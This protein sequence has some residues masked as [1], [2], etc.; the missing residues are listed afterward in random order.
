[1]DKFEQAKSG[2]TLKAA[3]EICEAY[4]AAMLVLHREGPQFAEEALR[5][6]RAR[7]LQAGDNEAAALFYNAI[8]IATALAIVALVDHG[9][10]GLTLNEN[11]QAA[12]AEARALVDLC[13]YA[14]TMVGDAQPHDI[15]YGMKAFHEAL[16]SGAIDV[17]S[18]KRAIGFTAAWKD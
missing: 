18:N 2:L 6:A 5:M 9:A 13:H 17:E 7:A 10:M 15:A 16:R 12:L 8:P 14:E 4:E 1:M 11:Q 3:Q